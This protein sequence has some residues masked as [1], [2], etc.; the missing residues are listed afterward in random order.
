MIAGLT[1]GSVL[2][3]V[4]LLVVVL[5]YLARPFAVPEDEEARLDREEVDSL[6]LRR[7]ALLRQIRELDEDMEAAKVAPE[8]Y[9]ARRPQL[10]KQAALLTQQLDAHGYID[11]SPAAAT[12]TDVDAEMEAAVRQLRTPQEVDDDIEAAV[13]QARQRAPNGAATAPKGAATAAV[14][15]TASY[16]PK[17]GRRV[18]ASDRF[19]P[20]CGHNLTPES[21]K[22]RPARA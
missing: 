14:A 18:D 3:G 17:C 1:L 2:L 6:V 13:R 12:A 21:T 15:T 11:G 20:K 16:C 4:A 10:V 22:A 7:D 19:C 8:M 5:L 9:Q